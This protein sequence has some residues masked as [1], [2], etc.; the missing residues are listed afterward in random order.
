VRDIIK[1]T[2]NTKENICCDE[3]AYLVFMENELA[4]G[5]MKR[6]K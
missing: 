6:E 1:T 5:I 2:K 4:V 3:K